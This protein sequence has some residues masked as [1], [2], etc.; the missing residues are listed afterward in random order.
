MRQ[1][2]APRSRSV[3]VHLALG[4]TELRMFA[5]FVAASLIMLTI[6]IAGIVLI[7]AAAYLFGTV[8][9]TLPPVAGIASTTLALWAAL[10]LLAAFFGAIIFITLRLTFLLVPVTVAENKFDLVRSWQLTRGN[11]WRSFWLTLLVSFP[12]GL[13]YLGIQFAFVGFAT[14]AEAPNLSPF[15]AATA[16]SAQ[17]VAL[18]ARFVLGWLP[19]FYGA[20]FLVRPLTVGLASGAAARA[21]RALVPD[22][23]AVSTPLAD[24]SPAAAST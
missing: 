24:G 22:A 8:A 11:F 4:A 5:A 9:G 2:L 21:Y 10:A 16:A 17:A 12:A 1:A 19:Y 6:E 13:L 23:L 20:W 7:V 14:V 18:R 15:S 3:F